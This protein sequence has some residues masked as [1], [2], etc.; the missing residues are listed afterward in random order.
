MHVAV[1]ADMD[2]SIATLTEGRVVTIPRDQIEALLEVRIGLAKAFW[3]TQL[4]DEGV[5]QATIVSMGRRT[6]LERVPHPFCELYFRIQNIFIA[7][8]GSVVRFTQIVLVA[9]VGC[10]QSM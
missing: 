1:F 4:I 3:W 7:T 10:P 2:L 8:E 6:N 9:A 5:L